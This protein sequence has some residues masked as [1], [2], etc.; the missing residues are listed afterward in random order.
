MIVVVWGNR[1]SWL[2]W[3]TESIENCRRGPCQGQLQSQLYQSRW[4]QAP[5]GSLLMVVIARI[6]MLSSQ[7]R[8]LNCVPQKN[9][10]KV[11]PPAPRNSALLGS[12]ISAEGIG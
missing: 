2:W 12:C 8:G 4:H 3:A 7:C 10:V 1:G 6:D 11:P 9:Y 5:M